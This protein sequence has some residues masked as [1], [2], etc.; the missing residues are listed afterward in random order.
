MLE[1]SPSSIAFVKR[2][3]VGAGLPQSH[4]LRVYCDRVSESAPYQPDENVVQLV[5]LNASL[6]SIQ[7]KLPK[8]KGA[9]G[10]KYHVLRGAIEAAYGSASTEY[11]LIYDGRQL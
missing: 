4:S 11:T 1:S 9:D 7:K 5:C 6:S 2:F 3:P 8:E 10:K